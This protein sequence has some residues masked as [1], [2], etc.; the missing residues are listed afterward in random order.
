MRWSECV[1]ELAV[2]LVW[3]WYPENHKTP[4]KKKKKIKR[5]LAVQ[6]K[7]KNPYACGEMTNVVC[8]RTCSLVCKTPMCL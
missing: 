4:N 7:P 6:R 2:A 5:S 3:C 1:T 8:T